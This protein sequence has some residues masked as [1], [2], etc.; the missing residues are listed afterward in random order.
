M[1]GYVAIYGSKQAD[2][3]ADTLYNAKLKAIQH[4]KVP[5]S[6]RDLVSVMLARRADGSQVTHSTASI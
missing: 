6:K 5:T 4:F 1:N 2:I 3:Y